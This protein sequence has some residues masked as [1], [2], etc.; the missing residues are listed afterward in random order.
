[1]SQPVMLGLSLTDNF[2][3]SYHSKLLLQFVRNIGALPTVLVARKNGHPHHHFERIGSKLL[4]DFL[5]SQGTLRDP[6]FA[7][8]G[9]LYLSGQ[10]RCLRP[11]QRTHSQSWQNLR[12]AGRMGARQLHGHAKESKLSSP[13]WPRC[14]RFS[15]A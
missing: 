4:F 14:D 9:R 1:M 6:G 5:R 12:Q 2:L 10:V 13:H 8:D 3:H 11:H 15:A 7:H